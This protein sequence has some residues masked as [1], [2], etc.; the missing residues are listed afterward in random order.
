MFTSIFTNDGAKRGTTTWNFSGTEKKDWK[1]IEGNNANS[2]NVEVEFLKVGNYSL[3]LV[4]EYS[5]NTGEEDD[6]EDEVALEQEY[7]VTAANYLDELQQIY[8]DSNFLKLVKKASDY[9]VKT[10]YANDPTPSIFLAKGYY[11]IYRE[12]LTDPI[13]SDPWEETINSI[14]AAIELDLNG[15]FNEKIHKMWL[16]K[17]QNDFL[18]N[19][20]IYNLEEKDGYYG[21]YS[22]TDKEK[23]TE[24]LELLIEGLENYSIITTQPISIQFLEAPIRAAS[25]DVRTA[26]TIWK[27]GIKQLKNMTE[28]DFDNMTDTDLKALKYGAMLSAVTLTKLRQ[29]NTEACAILSS[30][31]EVYAYDRAFLAFL[32]TRYNNCK[33]E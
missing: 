23:K 16:N 15:I 8:A 3:E 24:L 32:K 17:F 9:L 30:L 29:S 25:K 7:I 31:K 18:N 11:G 1:Y 27:N 13:V 2:E 4:V 33:E 26:N 10:E 12:E 22:G 6:E 14:T 20:L 5:Y 19:Y 21:I 28:S